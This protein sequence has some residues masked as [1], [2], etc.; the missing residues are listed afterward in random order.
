MQKAQSG[1]TR[2]GE[3][4]ADPKRE[5]EAETSQ[6]YAPDK[7]KRPGIR[8]RLARL[9]TLENLGRIVSI[10]GT[11]LALVFGKGYPLRALM[12]PHTYKVIPR[13]LTVPSASLSACVIEND[14]PANAEDVV[15]QIWSRPPVPFRELGIVGAEGQWDIEEGGEGSSYARI[16]LPRLVETHALTV[17]VM[18][19]SPIHLEC[20]V[21]TA[22]GRVV[23][24]PKALSVSLF[25]VVLVLVIATQLSLQ[26]L[27]VFWLRR[28]MMRGYQLDSS[29]SGEERRK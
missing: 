27:S 15:I 11:V 4:T 22:K 21:T 3:A 25:M 19:D 29:I 2:V 17:T 24:R 23:E 10:A 12:V 28:I 18:T 1:P 20:D 6:I 16:S 13:R 8:Q 26:G 5:S 14:G 9:F 7:A